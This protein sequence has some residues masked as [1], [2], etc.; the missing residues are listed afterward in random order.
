M[1]RGRPVGR[2]LHRTRARRRRA[3]SGLG[4]LCSRV[5]VDRFHRDRRW[6]GRDRRVTPTGRIASG[7]PMAM[8]PGSGSA[9]GGTGSL[10]LC[11]GDVLRTRRRR[12]KDGR[13]LGRCLRSSHDNG[14]KRASEATS[15]NPGPAA[16]DGDAGAGAT[17]AAATGAGAAA[18][19][20]VTF[21]SAFNENSS[22]HAPARLWER[23][24]RR[25]ASDPLGKSGRRRRPCGLARASAGCS[26]ALRLAGLH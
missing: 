5:V 2:S 21:G 8:R 3:R 13:A 25:S 10:D 11:P 4:F 22:C 17:G 23:S 9:A 26:P 20:T 12:R 24:D 7:P 14:C 19:A 16:G 6:L 1:H 15:G 18:A